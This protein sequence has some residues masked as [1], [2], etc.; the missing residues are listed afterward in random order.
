MKRRLLRRRR[1]RDVSRPLTMKRLAIQVARNEDRQAGLVL[2][3]ALLERGVDLHR[4]P[5]LPSRNRFFE[6]PAPDAD[7]A[8]TGRKAYVRFIAKRPTTSARELLG[9]GFTE[10]VVL[11]PAREI[12]YNLANYAR[13]AH[14]DYCIEYVYSRAKSDP[15]KE[16]YVAWAT[17]LR[18]IFLVMK[19]YRILPSSI[20]FRDVAWDT[21]HGGSKNMGF[22]I[23]IR[24][25][26]TRRMRVLFTIERDIDNEHQTRLRSLS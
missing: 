5:D 20:R 19:R 2:G 21:H 22:R 9:V 18:D 16:V 14:S 11:V 24:D 26:R 13:H 10:R 25:S 4:S 6:L 1:R 8:F 3:D 23:K 17:P 12:I 7:A 15:W